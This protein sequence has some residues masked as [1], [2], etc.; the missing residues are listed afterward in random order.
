MLEEML[1]KKE[2]E[3]G[4]SSPSALI[5]S[6]AILYI[7]TR[8]NRKVLLDLEH[9]MLCCA[10]EFKNKDILALLFKNT[11]SLTSLI[12][13]YVSYENYAKGFFSDIQQ[14]REEVFEAFFAGVSPKVVSKEGE[15]LVAAAHVAKNSLLANWLIERYNPDFNRR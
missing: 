14:A 15:R 2:N 3:H 5:I 1:K 6:N 10:I 13:S 12:F 11:V 7:E 9:A 8:G 4:T